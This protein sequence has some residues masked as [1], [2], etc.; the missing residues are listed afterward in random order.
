[1]L[2]YANPEDIADPKRR[3]DGYGLVRFNKKERTVTFECWPRFSDS[4]QGDAAQFPGWPITVPIDANDGRKPVAY[5]PELRFSGGLNPV[6]QVISESS[7]EELYILR[8]HGSR[9]QPAVYAPG[10]Y[11]V[12]VGRDRPDGPEI[13][14]VLATPDSA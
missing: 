11:T 10:S 3:A 6:V 14:G 8:A 9:F 7:G 2:A 4:S 5:L 1:M 13:K 12:R